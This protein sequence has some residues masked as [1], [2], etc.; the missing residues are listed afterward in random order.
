MYFVSYHPSTCVTVVLTYLKLA[1]QTIFVCTIIIKNAFQIF[2]LNKETNLESIWQSRGTNFTYVS[3]CPTFKT[4]LLEIVPVDV[5]HIGHRTCTTK[6]VLS[7][8]RPMQIVGVVFSFAPGTISGFKMTRSSS[9][10]YSHR[11][12]LLTGSL[13]GPP[14]LF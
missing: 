8:S 1:S 11:Y 6:P 12:T 4:K 13:L 3:S 10:T 2:L 14:L 9:V 7:G 5:N